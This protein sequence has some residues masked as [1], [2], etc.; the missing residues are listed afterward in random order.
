MSLSRGVISVQTSGWIYTALS[1]VRRWEGLFLSSKIDFKRFVDGLKKMSHQKE[2]I[3]D[4]SLK[5]ENKV[6]KLRSD[7]TL[8][9][10][11]INTTSD[12]KSIE[13]EFL[14]R[15]PPKFIFCSDSRL[16]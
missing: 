10:N 5:H 8:T 14:F 15:F 9:A 1:R 3:R 12:L 2:R 13:V 16:S 6:K 7:E 4:T 11:R